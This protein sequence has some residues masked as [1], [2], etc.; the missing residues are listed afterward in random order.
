[1]ILFYMNTH[2]MIRVHL[3][4][5]FV[6][7]KSRLDVWKKAYLR[8]RRRHFLK[9]PFKNTGMNL[10]QLCCDLCKVAVE[11]QNA[12]ESESNCRVLSFSTNWLKVAVKFSIFVKY[13][14]DT[15]KAEIYA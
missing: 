5:V 11:V 13:S 2:L 3:V 12:G 14:V 9:N 10:A 7:V 1:M 15:A 8:P 4:T 6:S